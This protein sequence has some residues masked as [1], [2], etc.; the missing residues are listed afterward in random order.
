MD[1]ILKV[2][3]DLTN[4]EQVKSIINSVNDNQEKCKDWLV[5]ESKEY[6]DYFDNPKVCVAAGWYGSLANKLKLY[7]DEQVL[8]FDKDP[9]TKFIGTKLYDDIFFKVESIENFDSYKNYDVVI[10]T[11]CEHLKQETIDNMIEKC[12]DGTLLILQS[13]NY[14]KIEDHIN[15][16]N[17]IK[18]FEDSLKLDK[19]MFGGTLNLDK[20]D[21]FMVI[22]VK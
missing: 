17:N 18:E 2:I 10:C 11:S 19:I 7:T 14:K 1:R 4:D 8:S 22:G 20:Y 16:H 13:N 9:N 3:D 6:L 21:R 12:K 5:S 15:C